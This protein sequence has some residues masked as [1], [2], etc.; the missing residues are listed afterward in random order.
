MTTTTANNGKTPLVRRRVFRIVAGLFGLGIL[1]FIVIQFIN[2]VNHT[3]PAPGNEPQWDNPKTREIANR[4]CFDCHSNY[5]RWPWYSYVAPMSWM[6]AD[7]VKRARKELNF[8]EWDPSM[9]ESRI[10]EVIQKGD[11]PLPRYLMLHPEARLSDADK[12][13]LI[14]G[15]IAT[16]QNS[17]NM[18]Q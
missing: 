17:Q 13:A 5:T 12:K 4:A 2:P 3:N 18:G 7:D 6:V 9:Q 16:V 15:M 1:V 10:V 11:M 14:D 8:T